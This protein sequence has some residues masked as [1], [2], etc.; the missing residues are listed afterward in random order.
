M[1]HWSPGWTDT[2]RYYRQHRV[3]S[4]SQAPPLQW[5]HR[6]LTG[7]LSQI[8]LWLSLHG[9][10]ETIW[11]QRYRGTMI[12]SRQVSA[13]ISSHAEV[14]NDIVGRDRMIQALLL[15]HYGHLSYTFSI[16]PSHHSLPYLFG[17]ISGIFMTISG[18]NCSSVFSF[19]LIFSSLLF[20]S[21]DRLS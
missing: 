11:H 8:G 5:V 12:S 3:H 17:R 4:S 10:D 18:L 16:N 7:R 14:C 20:D 1:V 21:C 13:T 19:V 9:L 2:M 15:I 6:L